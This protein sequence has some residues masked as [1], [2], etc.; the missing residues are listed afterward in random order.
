MVHRYYLFFSSDLEYEPEYAARVPSS[1]T[2]PYQ[3]HIL[4]TTTTIRKYTAV[5]HLPSSL[6]DFENKQQVLSNVFENEQQLVSNVQET[7]S[8]KRTF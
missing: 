4:E 6:D 7:Y 5:M 3:Y 1:N 8:S 2:N